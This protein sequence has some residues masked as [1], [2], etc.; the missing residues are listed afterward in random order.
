MFQKDFDSNTS[1]VHNIE[2]NSGAWL[3]SSDF[4]SWL[5]TITTVAKEK[6]GD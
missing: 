6:E 2:D 1:L 5:D 3:P 4:V